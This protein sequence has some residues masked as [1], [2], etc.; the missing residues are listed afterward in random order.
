LPAGRLRRPFRCGSPRRTPHMAPQRT[1]PRRTSQP[2]RRT[3]QP[4]R[5][6]RWHPQRTTRARR[7]C[8]TGGNQPDASPRGLPG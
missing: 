6:S 4:P 2:P 1:S 5:R 3:S 8:G 7:S